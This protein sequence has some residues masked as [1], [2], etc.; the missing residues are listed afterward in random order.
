[1]TLDKFDLLAFDTIHRQNIK[2]FRCKIKNVN[3]IEQFG[4]KW[5]HGFGFLASAKILSR[6]SFDKKYNLG[7]AV[8]FFW[9]NASRVF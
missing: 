4:Q 7:N 1:V 5:L 6:F 2:V 3:S 8:L 9:R